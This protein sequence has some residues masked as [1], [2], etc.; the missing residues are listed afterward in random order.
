MDEFG[1]GRSVQSMPNAKIKKGHN[2]HPSKNLGFHNNPKIQ[3]L[4]VAPL[5][6]HCLQSSPFGFSF[7]FVSFSGS[8]SSIH[9]CIDHFAIFTTAIILQI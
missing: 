1:F 8:S 9:I 2:V 5:L 6:L 3:F 4:F 7:F